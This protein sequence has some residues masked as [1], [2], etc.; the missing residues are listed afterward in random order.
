M[1]KRSVS[2]RWDALTADVKNI[3]AH[4]HGHD[5]RVKNFRK[6]YIHTTDIQFQHGVLNPEQFGQ[7]Y[8]TYFREIVQCQLQGNLICHRD[9][10]LKQVPRP[11]ITCMQN[12]LFNSNCTNYH[13]VIQPAW[14]ANLF[15][16]CFQKMH[17]W[18][19]TNAGNL[20]IMKPVHFAQISYFV[21]FLPIELPW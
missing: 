12:L 2:A 16:E 3:H 7:L 11:P 15:G 8:P 9:K 20:Q 18:K 21:Y 1:L 17:I 5:K 14:L 4:I 13:D 19:W 6:S 10:R